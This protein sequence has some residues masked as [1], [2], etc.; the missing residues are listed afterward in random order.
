VRSWWPT[1]VAFLVL[2]IVWQLVALHNRY[3]I[4][5]MP[6][7]WSQLVENPGLYWH[8]LLVT[9][10][11]AVVGAACGMSAAFILAVGMCQVPLLERAL[12]PLAVLVNVTPVVAI[13]PGL[14]V[15]FGFGLTPKYVVTAVIVFFPFLVNS[16]I[17][18]RS[19][20]PETHD[21]FTSLHASRAEVLLRLRLPNSLP[22]LFAAA[23]ICMPL[24]LIG[25]VVAEF[26]AP[27]GAGGLGS[28]IE[29][30]ASLADLKTVYASVVVLAVL[31][32]GLTLV[33]VVLQRS[34][35]DWNETSVKSR[36]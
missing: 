8:D 4:P 16:L 6:Q 32:I 22:F 10:Q 25:A 34:F 7:V 28:L 27:G 2:G 1:A 13:A 5:T 30:G 17:G 21:V 14:V 29:T 12:M 36:P 31:G 24:S 15:A 26:T 18:L 9:L 19:P 20:D 23:R 33:V 11:E 35:L 3:L